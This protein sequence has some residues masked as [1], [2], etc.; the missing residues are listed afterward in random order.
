MQKTS[1]RRRP[2]EAPLEMSEARQSGYYNIGQA[3]KLTGVS[4]KMIR[5]YESIGLVPAAQRTSA[6]YRVYS[7]DAIHTLNFVKRA[8]HLGFALKDIAVLLGLW[9]D[10]E[11]ASAEVKALAASHIDEIDQR[12]KALRAMRETLT[13]LVRNCRGD[14]RPDCP[15]LE[16]LA[17][18]AVAD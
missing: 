17:G 14:D 1:P 4:A 15:I 3:A 16:D 8:R 2:R 7:Q 9:Q 13:H 6:N 18:G 12:M 5:H 11:R 10:R